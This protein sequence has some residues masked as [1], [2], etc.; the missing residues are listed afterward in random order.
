MGRRSGQSLKSTRRHP[1]PPAE[2]MSEDEEKVIEDEVEGNEDEVEGK[3][4]EP[5]ASQTQGTGILFSQREREQSQSMPSVRESEQSELDNLSPATREKAIKTLARLILFKAFAGESIEKTKCFKDVEEE[6]KD[7][8]VGHSKRALVNA[9]FERAAKRVEDVFGFRL[10]AV[11]EQ[12]QNAFPKRFKDRYYVI[13]EM[14]FDPDGSQAKALHSVTAC[15]E[16]GVLMVILAFAFCKGTMRGGTQR[17]E[18]VRWIAD[19]VL[20]RLLHSVDDRIMDEP[21]EASG[22]ATQQTK[23]NPGTVEIDNIIAKFVNMDYL[24]KEKIEEVA[25]TQSALPEIRSIYAMGPRA[26]LEI[27][28]KQLLYFTAEVLDQEPDPAML[29]AIDGHLGSDEELDS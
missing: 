8:F 15:K 28:R 9:I 27:G 6:L 17:I 2:E 19:D 16:R 5:M 13:N 3:E 21:P 26:L 24:L 7:I 29:A 14:D 1:S 4:D 20:Y 25:A 18:G 22:R 11:P 12:F 10:A 23:R